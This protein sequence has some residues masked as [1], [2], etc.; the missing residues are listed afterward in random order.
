M[1]GLLLTS[2]VNFS[3]KVKSQL[4]NLIS[5]EKSCTAIITTASYI[6]KERSPNAKKT[7]SQYHSISAFCSS[8]DLL[9]GYCIF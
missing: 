9:S 6:E 2:T 8:M 4:Q 3:N 5:R 1:T 7:K